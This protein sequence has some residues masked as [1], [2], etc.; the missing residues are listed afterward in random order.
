MKR[1]L[2]MLVVGALVLV[3]AIF[4][5]NAE[6][7]KVTKSEQE[8]LEVLKKFQAGY[9][10]R[11]VSKVAEF[12]EELFDKQDS[13]ILGTSGFGRG[14]GEWYDGLEEVK[15][16]IEN[17]WRNW[18]DVKLKLTASGI[19]I[20]GNTAWVVIL[21]TAESRKVKRDEYEK[22][23]GSIYRTIEAN[24]ADKSEGMPLEVLLWVNYFSAKMLNEFV[25]WGDEYIYPLR[26]TAVLVKK[27]GKWMFRLMD[28][29]FPVRGGFPD[30]KITREE[31]DKITGR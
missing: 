27:S 13:I 5:L 6:N 18:D 10:A 19:R 17:D 16:I 31:I 21:G 20:E 22:V 24:K 15:K 29:T 25:P 11:D 2:C 28:F 14:Y 4:P 26:I 8:I 9:T 23:L 1:I 30:F 12:C 3:S 7:K